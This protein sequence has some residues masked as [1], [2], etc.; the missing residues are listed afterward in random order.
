[1]LRRHSRQDKCVKWVNEKSLTLERCW[2]VEG[3][4]DFKSD[5]VTGFRPTAMHI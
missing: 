5:E 1:M 2:V 4:L 3:T